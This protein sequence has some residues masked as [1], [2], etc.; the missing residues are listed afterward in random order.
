MEYLKKVTYKDRDE[1]TET[2]VGA[3]EWLIHTYLKIRPYTHQIGQFNHCGIGSGRPNFTF[4]QNGVR[5]DNEGHKEF[6]KNA[7]ST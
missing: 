5:G 7:T 6:I 1:H 2:V 4:L 3:Y